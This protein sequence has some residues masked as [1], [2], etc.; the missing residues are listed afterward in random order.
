MASTGEMLVALLVADPTVAGI[1]ATKIYPSKAPDVAQPPFI[2]YQVVIQT[3]ENTLDQAPADQTLA[4]ARVQIDCY[5]RDYLVS[6][7]LADAVEA[8]VGNLKTQ[9][10]SSWSIG[11][12]DL[13]DDPTESY[14]VLVEISVWR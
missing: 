14:R 12:H 10:I 4:N 7:Q 1:V 5:A 9:S 2:V 8:A 3:S 11:R 13:Y 6:Q